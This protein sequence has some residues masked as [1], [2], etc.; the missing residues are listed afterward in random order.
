MLRQYFNCNEGL[1]IFLTSFC[2]IVCYVGITY[3]NKFSVLSSQR[4]IKTCQM[5][6]FLLKKTLKK[7]PKEYFGNTPWKTLKKETS[8]SKIN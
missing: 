5:Y 6:F 2:N 8:A 4:I 3:K 7:C 1:E